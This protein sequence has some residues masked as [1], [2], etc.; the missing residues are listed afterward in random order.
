MTTPLGSRRLFSAIAPLLLGSLAGAD[1]ITGRV[2][3]PNGVG[4]AGVDID[5]VNL[6]SGGNPH[7]LNDGTDANGNFV[8]TVEPGVYEIRF[9]P[10]SPPATSLLT[11][12]LSNVVVVG[13]K[14]LGT[15]TLEQGVVLSGTAR[16]AANAPVAGVHVTVSNFNT[17]APVHLKNNDT[18]A[19]GLFQIAVPPGVVLETQFLT[20]GVFGQ[21]LVPRRVT[22]SIGA[23]TNLG[24]LPF[25]TGFHVTG[26]VH[27]SNGTGLPNADVDVTDVLTND[28]LF[29]P[30]DNTTGAGNFDVVVPAGTFDVD[31]CPP[32]GFQL[33]SV[34]AHGLVVSAPTAL[35]IMT[36]VNGFAL[37][38]TVRDIHGVPVAGADVNVRSATTALHVPLCHDNTNVNGLYSVLVPADV[39]DIT[40]SPPGFQSRF[41]KDHHYGVIV[42]GPTVLDGQFSGPNTA[43][44]HAGAPKT[45]PILPVP[46]SAGMPGAGQHVP[47]IGWSGGVPSAGSSGFALT[48]EGG[49]AG[50]LATAVLGLEHAPLAG[51]PAV[52][53]VR[54][55]ARI[56]QRLDATGAARFPLPPLDAALLGRT[57]YA[58]VLVLDPAASRGAALTQ[59]LRVEISH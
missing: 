40:F 41:E 18:N 59:V 39:L 56:Q 19:F 53:L 17:G 23:N 3:A 27:R 16:N 48:L 28:T 33:V 6:G 42:G 49:R 35:G 8:T 50:A 57:A 47:K 36:M 20:S 52:E 32:A 15:I 55:I 37:S 31:V 25:Q 24:N 46:F 22:G 34:A 14:P 38:G 26:T 29:T 9:F 1:A 44:P 58:Q 7:E 4:V 12:V 30:N 51:A 13:T 54:P 10:P 45:G 43:A 11:G 5:F 2:V 21:T